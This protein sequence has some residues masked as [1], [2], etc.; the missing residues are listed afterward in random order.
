MNVA[1]VINV[2]DD[3]VWQYN[4]EEEDAESEQRSSKSK[5]EER[6]HTLTAHAALPRSF[7]VRITGIRCGAYTTMTLGRRCAHFR[8]RLAPCL[9]L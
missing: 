2:N 7:Y 1:A 4:V 5:E 3:A 8:W 9:L 6:C